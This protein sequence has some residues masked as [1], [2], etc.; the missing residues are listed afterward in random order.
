MASLQS[1]TEVIVKFRDERDWAQFH[2]PKNLAAAISIE[3]AELQETMLW[4]NQ[5]EIEELVKSPSALARIGEEIADV[6]IY[7]IL[8]AHSLGIDLERAIESKIAQNAQR[9]PVELAR[10]NSKKHSEL[11]KMHS[12]AD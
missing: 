10:G 2:T 5:E 7:G 8:L 3:A 9:Y 11:F 4:K 6:C 12:E 1:L